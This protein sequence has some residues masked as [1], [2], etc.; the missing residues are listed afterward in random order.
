MGHLLSK[1]AI[2]CIHCLSNVF[3]IT[4]ISILCGALWLTNLRSRNSKTIVL[5]GG[6]VEDTETGELYK[7]AVARLGEHRLKRM[8]D[9]GKLQCIDVGNS[10]FVKFRKLEW[11]DTTS[12]DRS[13]GIGGVVAGP[14]ALTGLDLT[15]MGT[16][17]GDILENTEV[18]ALDPSHASVLRSHADANTLARSGAWACGAGP[19]GQNMGVMGGINMGGGQQLALPIATAPLP[20]PPYPPP[21]KQT[22][23]QLSQTMF[24]S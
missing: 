6:G 14:Q 7:E 2:V 13:W 1:T 18:G 22:P 5:F 21:P 12:L 19:M 15:D 24:S 3:R 16:F 17:L 4:C 9:E 10:T 23:T 20:L 8:I 11:S